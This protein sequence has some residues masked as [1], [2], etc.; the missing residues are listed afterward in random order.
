MGVD[1]NI[2]IMFISSYQARWEICRHI[3]L[4]N[5]KERDSLED[6]VLDGKIT[7]KWILNK[8]G[9]GVDWIHLAQDREK[10]RASVNTITILRLP[11]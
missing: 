2:V 7:I 5:L 10:W 8:Y 1:I 4:E 9:E 6:I 11:W 3:G